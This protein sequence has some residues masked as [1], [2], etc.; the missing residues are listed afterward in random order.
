MG[1]YLAGFDVIGVDTKP[2][3]EYPFA[4]IRRDAL[5]CLKDDRLLAEFDA[6][7]ASPPCNSETMLRF[8]HSS[9]TYVDL[10][11]PTLQ[12][13]SDLIDI[14]WVVENVESSRKMR[15][16]ITLCGTHFNLGADGRVLRRHRQFLASFPLP[17][18]GSCWC[19]GQRVGGVYG[20]LTNGG[21]LNGFKFNPDQAR[22]AMGIDWMSER[23][24]TLAIPPDYTRWVG[25]HVLRKLRQ[26]TYA[27]DYLHERYSSGRIER[28]ARL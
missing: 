6:I 11:T 16:S 8:M 27:R 10:L 28:F 3:R 15:G 23:G 20:S 22:K 21:A 5:S 9:R 14:P 25:E 12:L 2:Q 17:R 4:F 18:P 24:L 26:P 7:H 19:E 1:Y 13:L